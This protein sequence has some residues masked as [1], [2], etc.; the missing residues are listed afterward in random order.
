MALMIS[1]GWRIACIDSVGSWDFLF[2]MGQDTILTFTLDLAEAV[3][4]CFLAVQNISLLAVPW[5]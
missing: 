3:S 2:L 5:C 4:Q 1:E